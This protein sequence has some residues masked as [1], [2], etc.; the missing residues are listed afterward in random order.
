MPSSVHDL[1]IPVKAVSWTRLHPGLTADGR[2]SLLATM[3]QNNGGF[4]VIDAK[5]TKRIIMFSS[6]YPRITDQM[7]V[8]I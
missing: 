8:P 7:H 4:F 5:G 1:G 2:G 3:S 6:L